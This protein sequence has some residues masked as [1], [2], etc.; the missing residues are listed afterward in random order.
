[1]RSG[2]QKKISERRW[3]RCHKAGTIKFLP[4]SLAT[5]S[6]LSARLKASTISSEPLHIVQPMH[7]PNFLSSMEAIDNWLMAWWIT[8]SCFANSSRSKESMDCGALKLAA[9][10]AWQKHDITSHA[11]NNRSI[12]HPCTVGY[13]LFRNQYSTLFKNVSVQ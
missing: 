1:M 6:A 9:Y 13:Y 10:A 8:L 12:C 4:L 7:A 11:N 3:S 2:F 5:Y